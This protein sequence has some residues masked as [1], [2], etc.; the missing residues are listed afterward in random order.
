MTNTSMA[1]HRCGNVVDQIVRCDCFDQFCRPCFKGHN[2]GRELLAHWSGAPRGTDLEPKT[3]DPRILAN[4]LPLR[5]YQQNC[6]DAVRRE[7]QA[8]SRTLV[9][10]QP[11]RER[12]LSSA[13]SLADGNEAACW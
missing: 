10:N 5:P 4:S 1:C 3:L 8:N 13:M 12:P 11:A 2:C 9:V 7:L 6:V